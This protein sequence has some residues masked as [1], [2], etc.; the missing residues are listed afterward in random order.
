MNDI[1]DDIFDEADAVGRVDTG[2]GKQ[3]SQL[4]RNL[5]KVENDI[6]DAETHLKTLKQEK[7]KLSVENIPA[8]MDEMGVERLMI[9]SRTMSPVPLVRAKT[10]WREMSSASCVTRVSIRRPRP[11]YI[12]PR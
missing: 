2:T 11:T 4:V 3:L 7:H 6:D 5:R 10:T 12:H 1:F 9:S 8:L